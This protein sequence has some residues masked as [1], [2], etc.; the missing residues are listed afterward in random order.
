MV[1]GQGYM[2]DMAA[3]S[4]QTCH[5]FCGLETRLWPGIVV[6]LEKCFLRSSAGNFSLQFDQCFNVA[7]RVG[8]CSWFPEIQEE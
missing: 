2:A 6:L 7:F 1:Q 5:T 8:S 4:S 3:L